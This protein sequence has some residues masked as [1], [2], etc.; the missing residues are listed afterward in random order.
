MTSMVTT[1]ARRIVREVHRSGFGWRL[2]FDLDGACVE[3]IYDPEHRCCGP[4]PNNAWTEWSRRPGDDRL[5]QRQVQ[6]YLTALSDVMPYA[7]KSVSIANQLAAELVSMREFRPGMTAAQ[8]IAL[9]SAV[10]DEYER[11]NYSAA[12]RSAYGED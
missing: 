1:A 8:L 3:R 7:G 2:W 6:D 4:L 10:D 5:T 9:Q 11:V 12:G